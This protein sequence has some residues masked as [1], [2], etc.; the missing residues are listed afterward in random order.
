MADKR[1][2]WLPEPEAIDDETPDLNV[3]DE[4]PPL[5]GPDSPQSET[6]D[7]PDGQWRLP[8]VNYDQSPPLWW[9]GVHG[10]AGES[11]LASLEPAWSAAE[12]CWPASR[13]GD[14]NVVLVART[15]FNGLTAAQKVIEQWASG[16][17][18][19]VNVL[20]LVLIADSPG[21]PPKPLRQYA[22]LISGGVPRTWRLPWV[23]AWRIDP[24]SLQNSPRAVR[25]L[26]KDLS[27]IIDENTKHTLKE[28][29]SS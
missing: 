22:D 14:E 21:K 1:N 10:G 6:V 13:G 15:S 5:V 28:R 20:G 27:V 11:S 24:P 3:E 29:K 18:A 12:H 8:T 23:E 25:K 16:D 17:V 7:R 26:I 2:P 4:L 19:E 9:L